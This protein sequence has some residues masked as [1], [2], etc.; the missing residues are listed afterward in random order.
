[1]TVLVWDSIG[2]EGH[3]YKIVYINI[4]DIGIDNIST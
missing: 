3:L 1:M 4:H 2:F